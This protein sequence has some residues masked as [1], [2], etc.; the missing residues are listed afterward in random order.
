MAYSNL[1]V[2]FKF[3]G[4][5]SC[6]VLTPFYTDGEA[7]WQHRITPAMRSVVL[8]T[9]LG[10]ETIPD[11]DVETALRCCHQVRH[12]VFGNC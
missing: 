10:V 5:T 7:S 12:D 9:T 2:K 6:I 11:V 4:F 8:P 1:L 3:Q